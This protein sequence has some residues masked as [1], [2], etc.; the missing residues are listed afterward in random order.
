MRSMGSSDGSVPWKEV[1]E[2]VQFEFV[3][4]IVDVDWFG[5]FRNFILYNLSF[6]STICKHWYIVVYDFENF[7]YIYIYMYM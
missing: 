5:N 1:R 4:L 3:D 2:L 7:S 6:V